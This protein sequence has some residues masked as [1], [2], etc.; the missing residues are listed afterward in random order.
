LELGEIAAG[1]GAVLPKPG[2]GGTPARF[3]ALANWAA[4][5]L[6]AAVRLVLDG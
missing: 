5:D 3:S 6:R 1:C 4:R 2:S